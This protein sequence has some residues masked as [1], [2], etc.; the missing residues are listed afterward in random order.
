MMSQQAIEL[1][2]ELFAEF[3]AEQRVDDDPEGCLLALLDCMKER[4]GQGWQMLGSTVQW[5]TY[6][7]AAAKARE[8]YKAEKPP[9]G[10]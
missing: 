2:R 10:G 1:L 6:E 4:A 5:A 3:K 8:K 9:E 7:G